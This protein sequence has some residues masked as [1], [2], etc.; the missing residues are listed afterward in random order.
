MRFSNFASVF[1]SATL[2]FSAPTATVEERATKCSPSG[3]SSGQRNKVVSAFKSSGV[4]PTLIPSINPTVKLSVTYPA[5]AVNL[6][7]K[8]TTLRKYH[9]GKSSCSRGYETD[10]RHLQKP[11]LSHRIR[12]LASLA[13]MRQQPHTVS[14][15]WIQMSRIQIVL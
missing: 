12:S 15:W 14:S 6:G 1:L 7:N 4:V 5:K 13:T 2:A 11:S 3:I 10:D 9:F 8:F